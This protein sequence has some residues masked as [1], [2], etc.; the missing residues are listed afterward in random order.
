VHILH[1][2]STQSTVIANPH[3]ANH[4]NSKVRSTTHTSSLHLPTTPW[5]ANRVTP[6]EFEYTRTYS[7]SPKRQR[8]PVVAVAAQVPNVN[9]YSDANHDEQHMHGYTVA[10]P[11][12][13][14]TT[15]RMAHPDMIDM[16]NTHEQYNHR[17]TTSTAPMLYQGE[18]F[19]LGDTQ[20]HI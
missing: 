8:P 18:T 11:S 2:Y 7:I 10:H 4:T 16:T 13:M 3:C 19:V 6:D 20:Y 12:N 17:H 15:R 1:V 9:R 14:G 5:P